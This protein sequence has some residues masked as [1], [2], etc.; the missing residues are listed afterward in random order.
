M[1]GGD[2]RD[3]LSGSARIINAAGK[4]VT[5]AFKKG[6]EAAYALARLSGSS[7]SIMKDRSPSCGL[8]TPYC[9]GATGMGIGV[10]AALFVSRGIQVF[11]LGEQDPFPSKNFLTLLEASCQRTC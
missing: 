9:E 4:D 1:R 2:G 5:D 8:K 10:T 3:I 11:E 7:L 6:A